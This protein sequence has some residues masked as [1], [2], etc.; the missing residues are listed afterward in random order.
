MPAMTVKEWAAEYKLINAAEREDLKRRLPLEPVA[1]SVR[2]YFDLC[3]L[4]IALSGTADEPEELWKSRL[5][6]YQATLERWTRLAQRLQ[7]A[8][9]PTSSTD[10]R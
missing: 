5:K 1:E 3:K 9:Q 7:H 8:H 6:G 10:R 2:S 4:V